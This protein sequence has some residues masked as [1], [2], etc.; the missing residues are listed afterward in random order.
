MKSSEE[1]RAKTAWDNA[2]KREIPDA[3]TDKNGNLLREVG[4]VAA[5]AD[6]VPPQVIEDARNALGFKPAELRSLDPSNQIPDEE[7]FLPGD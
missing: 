5:L 7:L 1:A 2:A 4:R 6:H 3:S